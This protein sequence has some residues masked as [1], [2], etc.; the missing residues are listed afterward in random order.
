MKQKFSAVLF[1]AFV[2]TAMTL[3]GEALA[4]TGNTPVGLWAITFFRD[5]SPNMN[6]MATQ[7]ICFLP[8]GRWYST[9]YPNWSGQWFQKGANLGGNG[10]HVHVAGN[11]WRGAGNDGGQL[12]FVNLKLMA[13]PWI[14]WVD[15]FSYVVWHRVQ[16]VRIGTC[17]IN[18]PVWT[19]AD[20]TTLP[21]ETES[22]KP[23]VCTVP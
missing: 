10:D 7:H 16:F 6:Q 12:D 3:P 18:E 8:S 20:P 9:T 23:P 13:G 15:N 19:I 1:A 21:S 11:F 5:A 4:Q 17:P 22:V 2:L 14:E